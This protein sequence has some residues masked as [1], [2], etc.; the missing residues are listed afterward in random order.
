M[1]L[2][3]EQKEAVVAELRAQLHDAGAIVVALYPGTTVSSFTKFRKL[4]R[5]GGVYVR[6]IKN[7]LAKLALKDTPFEALSAQTTGALVYGVSTDSVAVAKLF[8]QFAKDN[9]SVKIQAGAIPGHLMTAAEVDLLASMPS[10]EELLAT[11]VGTM[12]APITQFVRTLNEVPGKF[13]RTTAAL[14][15]SKAA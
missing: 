11:L 3:R 12:Q 14:R 5:E 4:A 9:E 6:V 7:R 13:V 2:N 1:S 10:R 15:D 8:K